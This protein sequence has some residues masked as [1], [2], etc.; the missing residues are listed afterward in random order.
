MVHTFR[1]TR[2]IRRKLSGVNTP[3]CAQ[4]KA[5]KHGNWMRHQSSKCE[6]SSLQLQ[7]MIATGAEE[8]T[9]IPGYEELPPDT[10][11]RRRNKIL[12]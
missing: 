2:S 6:T 5:T 12:K 11:I 3:L 7:G 9:G 10:R 1:L 8:E 4:S